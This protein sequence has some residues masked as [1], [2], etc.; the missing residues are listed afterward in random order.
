M[1]KSSFHD[2]PRFN[3][4]PYAKTTERMPLAVNVPPRRLPRYSEPVNM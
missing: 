1:T 4:Q 2:A 3:E